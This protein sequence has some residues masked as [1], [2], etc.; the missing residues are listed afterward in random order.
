M[1]YV[2]GTSFMCLDSGKSNKGVLEYVYSDHC[3]DLNK[4]ISIIGYV[5]TLNICV[6]SWKAQLQSLVLSCTEAKYIAITKFV[7]EDIWSK[8]LYGKL[9]D[10]IRVIIVFYDK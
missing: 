2:Y 10:R 8:E 3:K 4:R 9:D 1:D 6:I 7:K 5:C